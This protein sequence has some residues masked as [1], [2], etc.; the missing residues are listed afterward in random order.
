MLERRKWKY[1]ID[2]LTKRQR[3]YL[4]CSD[5]GICVVCEVKPAT[6][7]KVTCTECRQRGKD[8]YARIRK[9]TRHK[10]L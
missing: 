6:D 5:A 1:E 4:K 3:R 8:Y 10:N 9:S 2:G 7:D